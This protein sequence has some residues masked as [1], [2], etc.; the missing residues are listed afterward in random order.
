MP[1]LEEKLSAILS[2]P[3]MMQIIA[4]MVQ[5]LGQEQ[6][7]GGKK[8]M[9]SVPE[10]PEIDFSML[11]NLSGLAGQSKIDPQQQALLHALT[12]YLS[13]SRIQKLDRAMRAAKIAKFASVF[14]NSGG[15]KLLSGR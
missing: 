12:P 11:Q 6:P 8:D 5:S 2:N 10:L 14:L 15:L 9:P 4:S 7:P 13:Q 1:E 3:Q